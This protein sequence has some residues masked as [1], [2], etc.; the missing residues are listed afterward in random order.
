MMC[1]AVLKINGEKLL[2]IEDDGAFLKYDKCLI[3][4]H[5]PS[6]LRCLAV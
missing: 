3:H 6:D 4:P 2:E 5:M 1:P